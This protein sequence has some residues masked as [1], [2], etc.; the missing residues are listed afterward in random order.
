MLGCTSVEN[1]MVLDD[2]LENNTKAHV[3]YGFQGYEGTDYQYHIARSKHG[4]T[5][6]KFEDDK[7]TSGG[8]CKHFVKSPEDEGTDYTLYGC[9]GSEEMITVAFVP[10]EH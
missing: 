3:N 5:Y 4:Y 6:S 2:F 8:V 7:K 10:R 9:E 1:E